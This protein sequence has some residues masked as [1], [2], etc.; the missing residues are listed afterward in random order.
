M[1]EC[2]IADSQGLE[3]MGYITLV[4]IPKIADGLNEK[5]KQVFEMT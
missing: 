2:S 5:L 1:L 4:D 3:Y